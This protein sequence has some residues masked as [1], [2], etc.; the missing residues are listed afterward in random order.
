M[1]WPVLSGTHTHSHSH[2]HTRRAGAARADAGNEKGSGH[3]PETGDTQQPHVGGPLRSGW[4]RAGGRGAGEQALVPASHAPRSP[5]LIALIIWNGAKHDGNG[6]LHASPGNGV[7][8]CLSAPVTV[9]VSACPSHQLS[10]PVW[11][12]T[13]L[14]VNQLLQVHHAGRPHKSCTHSE[15]GACARV[16]LSRRC[17]QVSS[18]LYAPPRD[19]KLH[20]SHSGAGRDSQFHRLTVYRSAP[21]MG[22]PCCVESTHKKRLR[23][24]KGLQLGVELSP[25][26]GHRGPGTADPVSARRAG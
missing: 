15:P 2:T 24:R 9:S 14:W 5:S 17:M 3:I 12:R 16:C 18:P 1:S 7:C 26:R 22:N 23:S 6:D 4:G 8:L 13:V 19:N 20:R 25:G 10:Q 11:P 21:R